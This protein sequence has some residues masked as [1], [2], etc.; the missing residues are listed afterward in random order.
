MLYKLLHDLQ[1]A[2]CVV[3]ETHLREEE[4]S[5]VATEAYYRVTEY[6]R[7]IPPGVR[8][9]EGVLILVHRHFSAKKLPRNVSIQEDIEHCSCL[10][11]PTPS[12]KTAL[13]I[14]GVYIPPPKI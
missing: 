6:C 7:V 13:R 12:P 3:T 14:T 1:A 11:Y 10:F 5:W 8:P 2:L 4:L 9:G